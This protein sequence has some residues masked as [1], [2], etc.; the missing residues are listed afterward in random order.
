MTLQTNPTMADKID[1][2]NLAPGMKSISNAYSR[3][4]ASDKHTPDGGT[5][6]GSADDTALKQEGAPSGIGSK[7]FEEGIQDQYQKVNL[8]CKSW[9]SGTLL[10]NWRL[11]E[12]IWGFSRGSLRRRGIR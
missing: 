1:K 3:G 10:W 12:R 7:K 5:R 8:P 4:G 2:F 9:L 6:A 11:I